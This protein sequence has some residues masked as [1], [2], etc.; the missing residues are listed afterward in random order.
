[1]AYAS[2]S[3]AFTAGAEPLQI[4]DDP[5]TAVVDDPRTALIGR[6]FV[7]F[8][9]RRLAAGRWDQPIHGIP[10]TCAQENTRET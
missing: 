5:G 9:T 6:G 10:E 8:E 3:G 1:V 2:A 7:L 4:A